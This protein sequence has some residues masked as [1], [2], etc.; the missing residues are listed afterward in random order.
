MFCLKLQIHLT[1]ARLF[2][3]SN[4]HMEKNVIFIRTIQIDSQPPINHL[5]HEKNIYPG[6]FYLYTML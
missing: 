4:L 3:K 6:L 2:E 1:K 5:L